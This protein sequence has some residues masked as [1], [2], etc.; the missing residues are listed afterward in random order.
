[1]RRGSFA[2]GADRTEMLKI[3]VFT[4]DRHKLPIAINRRLRLSA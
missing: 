2:A 4:A 1:M 3:T